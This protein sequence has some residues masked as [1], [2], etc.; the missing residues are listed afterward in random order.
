MLYRITGSPKV[1]AEGALTAGGGDAGEG[2]AAVGGNRCAGDVDGAGVA[3]SRV[4]VGDD[5]L[6]GVIRVSRR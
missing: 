1:L 6:L 3:A 4:V 2:S 5:N